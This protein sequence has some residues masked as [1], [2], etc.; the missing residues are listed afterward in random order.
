[1]WAKLVRR[2]FKDRPDWQI[3]G[4]EV[5][6][7]KRYRVGILHPLTRKGIIINTETNER[8]VVDCI[9]VIDDNNSMGMM[10]AEMLEIEGP[11]LGEI[12]DSK[13]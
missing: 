11:S 13:K 2:H 9:F 1:M 5:P 10:V 8:R 4:D 12:N 7:G 6:L 3:I